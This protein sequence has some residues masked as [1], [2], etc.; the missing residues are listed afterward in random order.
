MKQKRTHDFFYNSIDEVHDIT[1]HK[2][3][4]PQP[5]SERMGV[6]KAL[7]IP[8]E[9]LQETVHL[10]RGMT[11]KFKKIDERFIHTLADGEL[12]YRFGLSPEQL[13]GRDLFDFL[14]AEMAKIKLE[15]YK[16]A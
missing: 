11:F 12:L 3:G 5:I 10:Q 4:T 13:I 14:P 7:R 6:E 2:N 8:R 15:H 9:E 1:D 16:K